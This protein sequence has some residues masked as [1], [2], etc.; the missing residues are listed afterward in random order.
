MSFTYLE[1]TVLHSLSVPSHTRLWNICKPDSLLELNKRAQRYILWNCFTALSI[2]FVQNVG[3]K[4]C[5][6]PKVL[7]T[8]CSIV[9]SLAITNLIGMAGWSRERF[10][11]S[12]V[13]VHHV[14]S[15]S[16][17]PFGLVLSLSLHVIT[18]LCDSD[19]A[20]DKLGSVC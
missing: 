4:W 6:A 15:T 19:R 14:L 20:P 17:L 3:E 18:I 9:S 8:L 2:K 10:A 1:V 5:L 7:W 16:H 12:V 11:V 13:L